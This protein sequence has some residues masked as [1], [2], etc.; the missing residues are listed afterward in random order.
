LNDCE[1][2]GYFDLDIYQTVKKW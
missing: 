2:D 1:A